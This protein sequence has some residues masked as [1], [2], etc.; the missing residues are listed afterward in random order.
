MAMRAGSRDRPRPEARNIDAFGEA[1]P[2]QQELVGHVLAGERVVGDEAVTVG[3]D[4]HQPDS[5]RF[6]V[7]VA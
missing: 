6:S 4:P 3:L 5:G 1:E 2:H 7:A